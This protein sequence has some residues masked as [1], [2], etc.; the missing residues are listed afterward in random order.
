MRAVVQRV[1]EA[2]VVVDSRV[3]AEIGAG[4]VVL[5]GVAPEDTESSAGWMA[6]KVAG[7]RIFNDDDGKM[8]RSV[9]EIGGEVLVVSQF[10]LYGDARKGKRPSFV[11]AARGP[12]AQQLYEEVVERLRSRGLHC[13]TGCFGAMMDV[14]LTN[15]GPVTI[16]LDSDKTF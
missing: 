7:L 10:T 6:E 13:A 14:A 12:Q 8:N 4:L 16:L 9:E 15:A 3:I 1:S 2:R 11:R 5:L